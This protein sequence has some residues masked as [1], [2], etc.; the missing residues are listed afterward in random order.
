MDR[1]Q[2]D[3]AMS[4]SAG[5]DNAMVGSSRGARGGTSRWRSNGGAVSE[6]SPRGVSQDMG[7]D[8]GDETE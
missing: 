6:E 3:E 5:E 1:S 8:E 4:R 2:G 7:D